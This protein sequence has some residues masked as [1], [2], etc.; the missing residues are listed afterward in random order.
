MPRVSA[1]SARR[2]TLV[3]VGPTP[4]P[5][6]GQSVMV[7]LLLRDAANYSDVRMVPVRTRYSRRLNESGSFSIFKVW[8]LMGVIARVTLARARAGRGPW[9]YFTPAGPTRMAML[10]DLALLLAVRWQ[11]AGLVLH[12]HAAGMTEAYQRLPRRVRALFAVAYGRPDL[13]IA[14]SPT[15]IG[16]GAAL[17]ARRTVLVPNG[18]EDL[19]LDSRQGLHTPARLLFMGLVTPAKGV[20]ELV[21]AARLLVSRGHDLE[22]TLAGEVPERY[23]TVLADQITTAGL[24]GRVHLAG[25]VLGEG[26][27]SLFADSDVF[28]FPSY[29]ESESFGM[30]VAEAMSAGLPVVT[31]RWRGIPY[32]VDDGDAG[33]LVPPRNARAL[34][35]A[36]E[37]LLSD[38]ALRSRLIDRGRE[39]YEALFTTE[40]HL[41]AMRKTLRLQ[42]EDEA[43]YA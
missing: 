13:V 4:P 22:L 20:G 33:L 6:G 18:V 9:L 23:R 38:A 17:G 7:D 36:V 40:A 31:T 42:K 39:R 2:T 29:F 5:I 32:V 35:D 14:V 28:C 30:V 26:K 41:A 34:A 16:E 12:F 25:V 1:A 11:F 24:D 27:R 15:G 43:R 10:R 19:G 37:R 8:H 21:E 3:V